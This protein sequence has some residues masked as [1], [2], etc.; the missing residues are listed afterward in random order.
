MNLKMIF[1]KTTILLYGFL[2]FLIYLASINNS[3]GFE[4]DTLNISFWADSGRFI[5]PFQQNHLLQSTL[6]LIWCNAWKFFGYSKD[7]LMP[8]R[9]LSC[10]FGA[11]GVAGFFILLRR[12]FKE[13]KIALFGSLSLA[14]STLYWGFSTDLETHLL[15]TAVFI[16]CL[17]LL[18]DLNGL[19][20]KKVLL[21]GL[22]HGVCIY[23]SGIYIFFVPAV[24]A[25]IIT[26]NDNWRSRYRLAVWYLLSLMVFWVI[27]F[28]FIGLYLYKINSD[29]RYA[30]YIGRHLYIWFRGFEKLIP[31]SG[32]NLAKIPICYFGAVHSITKLSRIMV[33]IGIIMFIFYTAYS[34][35]L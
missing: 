32:L 34:G 9:V 30:D 19:D 5:S 8:L 13:D 12:I 4:Y 27:P 18:F 21:L 6:N 10:I 35:L 7:C 11:A 15:P 16:Y 25:G 14:F 31:F 24:I 17:I 2:I 26:I 28:L 3:A 33:S 23:L 29:F 1:R 20:R 22:I